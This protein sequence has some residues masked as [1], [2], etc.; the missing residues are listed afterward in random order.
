MNL[1]GPFKFT[2]IALAFRYLIRFG[3]LKRKNIE[4]CKNL[5][6]EN[7][8]NL[9]LAGV[10]GQHPGHHEAGHPAPGKE[11]WRQEDL[12]AHL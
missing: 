2:D 4:G 3:S 1:N 8:D 6:S 11:G 12:W 5:V 9:L 10:E 7:P